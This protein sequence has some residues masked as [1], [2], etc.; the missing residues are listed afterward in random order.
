MAVR[1]VEIRS[2]KGKGSGHLSLELTHSLGFREEQRRDNLEGR[3][4]PILVFCKRARNLLIT[5]WLMAHCSFKSA[6]SLGFCG[7]GAI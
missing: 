7:G 5:K 3:G 6:N 1:L 2:V 4:I